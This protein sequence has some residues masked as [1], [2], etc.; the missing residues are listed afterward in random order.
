MKTFKQTLRDLL[1]LTS[2]DEIADELYNILDSY[3]SSIAVRLER[4]YTFTD[5]DTK[6]FVARVGAF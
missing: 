3:K 6:E 1:G 5:Y 2:K 4:E